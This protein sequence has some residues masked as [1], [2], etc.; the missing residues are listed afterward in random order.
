M[1]GI[2]ILLGK[3]P[4][5]AEGPVGVD[6]LEDRSRSHGNWG[7]IVGST[8]RPLVYWLWQWTESHPRRVK[9]DHSERCEVSPPLCQPNVDLISSSLG[10]AQAGRADLDRMH[11]RCSRHDQGPAPGVLA[12]HQPEPVVPRADPIW[13]RHDHGHPVFRE[14]RTCLAVKQADSVS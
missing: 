11:C 5:L 3:L 1:A 7:P 12:T 6:A 13:Q 10:H 2:A 8:R 9:G 4:A 14:A